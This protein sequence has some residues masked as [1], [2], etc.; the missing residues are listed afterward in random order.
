MFN[1]KFFEDITQEEYALLFAFLNADKSVLFD[2]E[3]ANA[4]VL[5]NRLAIASNLNEEG[6]ALRLSIFD[7]YKNATCIID[8][9]DV[10]IED[11][12]PCLS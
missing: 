11:E 8:S 9:E 1:N 2:V 12:K 10:F 5:L 7:K 6:C 4:R 3:N